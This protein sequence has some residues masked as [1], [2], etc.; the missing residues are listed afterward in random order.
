MATALHTPMASP[1]P[2]CVPKSRYALFLVLASGGLAVDL[3]TKD[4]VFGRLGYPPRHTI[5][6]VQDIL[7]L[8]TSLNE[9]AL[10]G[11]G[12]GK[13]TLFAALSVGAGVG[14]VYWLFV[15]K[16]AADGLLTFALGLISG[17]IMGNLYDRMG[18]HGMTWARANRLNEAGERVYAVRDWIHFQYRSFDWPVFNIADSLLVCGAALLVWHALRAQP[19]RSAVRPDP[20]AA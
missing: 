16:A 5:W 12:Q 1:A 8:E 19:P 13:V 15:A 3:L 7:S 11:I 2:L 17:G 14:I 20:I 10:F 18:W 6:L 4:W 9:G